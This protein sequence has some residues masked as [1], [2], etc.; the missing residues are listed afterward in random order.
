MQLPRGFRRAKL[1]THGACSNGSSR[2]DPGS[3]HTPGR[4]ARWSLTAAGV[5]VD[6]ALHLGIVQPRQLTCASS[7][8]GGKG[9]VNFR[10]AV[11]LSE[12]ASESPMESRLRMLLVLA[13]LPRP[14]AQVTLKDAE[15]RFLGR[16]D[17]YYPDQR[18]GL[19]YDGRI[20][21]DQ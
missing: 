11:E 13:G 9:M 16:P 10:A 12:P 1:L 18:V 20:H 5:L 7:V 19:E 8:P 2:T 3:I 17:L 4:P 21:R 14:Q 15:G 6:M